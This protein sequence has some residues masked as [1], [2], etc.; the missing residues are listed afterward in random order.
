MGNMG[1]CSSQENG[2][3]SENNVDKVDGIATGACAGNVEET[4]LKS[5]VCNAEGEF[6]NIGQTHYTRVFDPVVNG[7][8]YV[9]TEALITGELVENADKTVMPLVQ[10]GNRDN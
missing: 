10:D 9:N 8:V 5:V 7:F 6:K 2:N 1:S 3:I 4:T